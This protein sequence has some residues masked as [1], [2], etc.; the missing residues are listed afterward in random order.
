MYYSLYTTRKQWTLTGKPGMVRA[1][2]AAQ[3][4]LTFLVSR[5]T[6]LI[7]EALYIL[8]AEATMT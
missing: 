3:D 2:R 8:R 5:A 6:R 4:A 7:F 1:G